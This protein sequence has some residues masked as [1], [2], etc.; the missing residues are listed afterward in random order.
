MSVSMR[1]TCSVSLRASV[2]STTC[3]SAAASANRG[4]PPCIQRVLNSAYGR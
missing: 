3:R 4:R 2:A 1:S